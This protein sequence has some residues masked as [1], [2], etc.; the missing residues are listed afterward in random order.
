[1]LTVFLELSEGLGSYISMGRFGRAVGKWLGQRNDVNE[2]QL[3]IRISDYL[4]L[5]AVF[6]TKFTLEPLLS[7]CQPEV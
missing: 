6:E 3:D 7:H 2:F 5:L 4:E 1:M